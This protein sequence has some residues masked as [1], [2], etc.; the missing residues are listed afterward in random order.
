MEHIYYTN[1]SISIKQDEFMESADTEMSHCFS[2]I[3]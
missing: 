3:A 1:V 2:P